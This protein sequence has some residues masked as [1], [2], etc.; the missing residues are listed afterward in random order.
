MNRERETSMRLLKETQRGL[1]SSLAEQDRIEKEC[2]E[3][4]DKMIKIVEELG[5]I[6][7]LSLLTQDTNNSTW[8]KESS[9]PEELPP[10]CW[11]KSITRNT[12]QQKLKELEQCLAKDAETIRS[13]EQQIEVT[14][15][16][17]KPIIKNFERNFDDIL[18]SGIVVSYQKE[19][20][21]FQ[22]TERLG[23]C[24]SPAIAAIDGNP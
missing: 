24:G 18:L 14:T 6:K 3:R 9:R 4:N 12:L 16:L 21:A 5:N 10:S 8:S 7:K 11:N 17:M 1:A 20:I 19:P 2:S 15:P 13:L 22:V 23:R